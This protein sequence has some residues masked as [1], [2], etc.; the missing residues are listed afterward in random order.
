MFQRAV[1]FDPF[2]PSLSSAADILSGLT[3][4][5]VAAKQVLGLDPFGSVQPLPASSLPRSG[6]HM[7]LPDVKN[8][9]IGV[10]VQH[11]S[12][13]FLRIL[14]LLRDVSTQE[15]SSVFRVYSKNCS[16]ALAEPET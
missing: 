5:Q 2:G 16:E 15:I 6:Q 4:S 9:E 12:R 1:G 13:I 10:M 11:D 14:Y 3:C 7:S 8:G